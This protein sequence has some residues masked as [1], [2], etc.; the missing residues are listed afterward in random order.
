MRNDGGDAKGMRNDGE[1]ATSQLSGWF[2]TGRPTLVPTSFMKL[3]S[4]CHDST[5]GNIPVNRIGLSEWSESGSEPPRREKF[6]PRCVPHW[7]VC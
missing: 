3:M 6:H 1:K 4:V 7:R 5:P 2:H